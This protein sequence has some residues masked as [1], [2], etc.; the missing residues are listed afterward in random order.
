MHAFYNTLH[1]YRTDKAFSCLVD[2]ISVGPTI[3]IKEASW[4][5]SLLVVFRTLEEGFPFKF[6]VLIV[7][8]L[9][10]FRNIRS[11]VV[12]I[13][14]VLS[15]ILHMLIDSDDTSI[16][17][18]GITCIT[19]FMTNHY[20]LIVEVWRYTFQLYTNLREFQFSGISL[21]YLKINLV[22]VL[23]LLGALWW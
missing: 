23:Q 13:F 5:F 22:L 15:F 14:L 18:W 12:L 20:L 7:R 4:F 16:E 8:F 21:K 17:R 6:V 2:L 9:F 11:Y 1:H 3:A 19:K 10:R